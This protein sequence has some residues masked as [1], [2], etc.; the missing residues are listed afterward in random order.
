MHNKKIEF[1]PRSC[2]W[3]NE[4]WSFCDNDELVKGKSYCAIHTPIV[5][6][7]LTDEEEDELID[8]LVKEGEKITI[9]SDEEEIAEGEYED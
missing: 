4:D 5:Y 1:I 9:D 8:S 7:M 3:I 2:Q 6:Q